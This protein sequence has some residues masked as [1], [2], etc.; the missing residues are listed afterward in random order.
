MLQES[1][2]HD[3]PR[4]E[5]AEHTNAREAALRHVTETVRDLG[6]ELDL[7]RHPE[8]GERLVEIGTHFA[9]SAEIAR[10]A[11]AL[12]AD[13]QKELE[14]PDAT[15]ERV[16]RAAVLHDIGK[17]GPAGARGDFHAAVRALFVNPLRKFDL[18]RD[19]APKSV[20]DYLTEQGLENAGGIAAALT[21]EGIDPATEPMIV[22]WRR[23]AQWTHDVLRAEPPS[24]DIDAETVRIAASHHMI[25][26]L[27]PADLHP[28]S[29]AHEDDA[30]L[31]RRELVEAIDKYQAYRVRGGMTHA[32]AIARLRSAV[33]NSKAYPEALRARF[34]KTIAVLERSEDAINALSNEKDRS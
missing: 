34:E 20:N 28:D 25:E 32:E 3:L 15:P 14:L 11:R 6:I 2:F 16:M 30:T 17:S 10:I 4:S 27:N 31:A 22:F 9:D 23:H 7:S 33:A 26:G 21:A 1:A 19:G 8:I 24:G 5:R 29:P 12:Y 13:L 18:Y